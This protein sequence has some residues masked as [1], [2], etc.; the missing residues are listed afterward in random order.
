MLP[1]ST[2][3]KFKTRSGKRKLFDGFATELTYCIYFH[4]ETGRKACDFLRKGDI[5]A[6][7]SAFGAFLELSSTK[8]QFHFLVAKSLSA[9]SDGLFGNYEFHNI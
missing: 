5:L 4:V 2:T 9:K 7:I 8:I 6:L 1:H 3:L